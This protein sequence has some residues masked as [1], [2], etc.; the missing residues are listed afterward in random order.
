MSICDSPCLLCPD[1]SSHRL[2]ETL[3]QRRGIDPSP[4][5]FNNHSRPYLNYSYD[6]EIA[7][8]DREEDSD[9]SGFIDDTPRDKWGNPIETAELVDEEE[10]EEKEE[11]EEEEDAEM[12][13]VLGK[14]E[15]EDSE[16]LEDE[17]GEEGMRGIKQV[18]LE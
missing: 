15:R 13:G 11:E 2:T 17:D 1:P 4:L 18:P 10:E 9:L 6:D 3:L 16:V 5:L 8:G 12:N 7:S 14:R